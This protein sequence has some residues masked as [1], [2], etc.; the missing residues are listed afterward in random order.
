MKKLLLLSMLLSFA[1]A[2]YAQ[3]SKSVV[4]STAGTLSSTLTVDELNTVTNLTITGNIDARD[5][6]TMRDLMPVLADIDLS[7]TTILEYNGTG[8]TYSYSNAANTIPRR[9]FSAN[10]PLSYSAK[11]TLTSVVLPSSVTTIKSEAFSHCSNLRYINFPSSLSIIESYSFMGCSSLENI[12]LS[13]AVKS[14]GTN[15][16]TLVKADINVDNGNPNYSSVDGV[17]YNKNK[18]TLIQCPISKTG[19]FSIPSSVSKI[20]TRAFYYCRG[21]TSIDIPSSVS[22]FE[23][24]D[25]WNCGA[26]YACSGLTTINIPAS[27]TEIGRETFAECVNITSIY[28]NSAIPVDLSSSPEVFTNIDKSN[29]KLYV[30]FGTKDLYSAANQWNEFT[31]IIEAADVFSLAAVNANI[32]ASANST[33]SVELTANVNWTASSDQSWLSVSPSS[34]TASATLTLTAAANTAIVP[35]SA[36][37]TVSAPGHS[38]QTLLVKQDENND[39]L[40]ISAGTL[41]TTLSPLELA[42]ATQLTLTGTIDASDFKTMRD[43]MP[44]LADIDLS[45]ASI[46]AYTG[47][48]GTSIRGMTNY[49]AGAI[50]EHAFM[51]SSMQGKQ[52]LESIVLPTTA[53]VLQLEAFRNCPKLSNVSIGNSMRTILPQVFLNC[54]NLH[55]INIP[56]SV[57]SISG[58]AFLQSP[59]S[60]TV[61][62]NNPNYS[63]IDGVLYNKNQTTLLRFPPSQTG[64]FTIPENVVTIGSNAFMYSSL[65]SVIIPPSVKTIQSNAFFNCNGINSVTIPTSVSSIQ[66]SAFA[67]CHNLMSVTVGQT[68]PIDLTAYPDVFTGIKPNCTLNVPYGTRSLYTVA[69]QWRDFANIMEPAN[70]FSLNTYTASLA[71]TEGSTSMVNIQANV[72]WSVSSDQ[73]WLNVSPTSGSGN[74][75]FTLT[76]QQ[77]ATIQARNATI[78][79]SSAG[80]DSQA[81]LV[82]QDGGNASAGITEGTLSSKF[83][84][85]ELASITQLTLTGTIDARDFKTMRDL[86]PLLS[87]VDL[88]GAIIVEYTGISGTGG[89]SNITYPAN[90]VPQNAFYNKLVLTYVSIPVSAKKI[91]INAF[92]QCSALVACNIPESVSTIG[93][94][95]FYWCYKLK[96]IVIPRNLESIGEYAFHSCREI[97]SFDIPASTVSIGRA[98]ILATTG[99][100]S[101]DENNTKY[102]S[103]N[104]VL[105]DKNKTRLIYCPPATSGDFVIPETVSTIAVDAFYNCSGLTSISVPSGLTTLEDWAFEE[106][107]GLTTLSLPETLT[108]IGSYA[109]YNCSGLASIYANN[110]AP[111]DLSPKTDVFFGID[112]ST[113]KL[114]VPAGS[115]NLYRSANQWK[116]FA[117]ITASNQP[118]VANAGLD[119]TADEG[120]LVTLDGTASSDSDGNTLTYLWTTPIGITLSSETAAK[121]TFTAPEVS[122]DTEFIFSLKV[123]DGTVDSP[124]D[125]VIVTVKHVNKAPVVNSGVS[126][127]VDE[128]TLVMLDGSGSY[129]PDGDGL[130]YAWV[131]PAGVLLSSETV[132]KPTFLAP[133][134]TKDTQL[135]F[136]LYVGDGIVNSDYQQVVVTVKHVNKMP[137]A[138]A[139]SDQNVN[140]GSTAT[141]DGSLSSDPDGDPLIYKW[142]APA[143]ITLSSNSVQKPTFT[144][145]SISTNTN[146]TFTL[147][148]NDGTIDSPADQVVVTVK[149]QNQVPTA[150]AGSDQ[151]VDEGTTAT[152]DGALSSDPDGDPLIYKWTAPAGITLSSTSVQKPT[153]TAP[154]VSA[155]TNY[156]FTLVVNDGADDSLADQVIVSVKNVNHAPA[157]SAGSDQNVDEGTT[158]TLDGSL[159]NDPDGDPLT[160]QW[161]APTG[162]VLSSATSAKPTFTAPKV[163]V[164]TPYTF[165]LIVNDGEVNSTSAQVIVWVK[166]VP[167]SL[168]LV[169][170]MNN[171]VILVAELSYQLYKKS[172]SSFIEREIPQVVDGNYSRFVVEQGEWIVLVSPLNNAQAFTPTYVGNVIN[173]ANAEIITVPDEGTVSKTIDCIALETISSGTGEISGFVFEKQLPGTKSISIVRS[174][175]GTETPV[176]G[177]LVHLYKKGGATPV[178]S[179]FTNVSGFYKFEKLAIAQHEIVIELPGFTQSE[180][181]P[182][183]LS[184]NSPVV[185]VSFAVSTTTQVITTNNSWLVSLLKI[186]PNP[187]MG[188]VAIDLG[189][190]VDEPVRMEVYSIQGNLLMQQQLNEQKTVVDLSRLVPGS[191]LAKLKIG[192]NIQSRLI[193][194]K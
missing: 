139:G 3:V 6:K 7:G 85:Q 70:G 54:W 21:L 154:G 132:A 91:G 63:S 123:N 156:T 146:Y 153:F 141:L 95:A 59:T 103:L 172:G 148:V 26:F 62:I 71:S 76:A 106:C 79:V 142:T 160:Y 69:N 124:E 187:T 66:N 118:P 144:A 182:V 170:R 92:R 34:G 189:E 1:V 136:L 115:E 110:P 105:Y 125:L 57:T 155:N 101:V 192:G 50:P 12:Q 179:C 67:Y 166:Q 90:E 78:T 133:E 98:A 116:D 183:M 186:Y 169:S 29:A 120:T 100:V 97:A 17:L 119:Q 130:Q 96:D 112:K 108:N 174:H 104:G 42:L 11:T 36:T 77:N 145:P 89:T 137:T 188:P 131:A 107:T 167:P 41:S 134:V 147:I 163:I 185:S 140:E 72:A 19:S 10:P 38:S 27:V 111:V 161:T 2:T 168:T 126:Q 93:N 80:I 138:N 127:T 32:G 122:K 178:S 75:T 150:N 13:S 24:G 114:F 14:I 135:I 99:T 49:I 121:P 20:G 44:I 43:L 51:N 193:M 152:L 64:S 87:R 35:R 86:M 84:V 61:D 39:P 181:L 102:S 128:G 83:T 15:A 117:H 5:F 46:V 28:V 74:N 55:S 159:S 171:A 165:K 73:P 53:M 9:S 191:Y 48:E 31:D 56:A 175:T 129:D 68:A 151:N 109:F 88:N 18:T 162:I 180:K 23:N 65:S 190:V 58:N 37:V 194:K 25:V 157:A 52:T 81:I 30:P 16:F 173:W 158:V 113:C 45:G 94:A 164:D 4:L 176:I 149:N 8:T 60:I 177:A 82:T 33:T 143:G 40:S 184:E 22:I 47:T